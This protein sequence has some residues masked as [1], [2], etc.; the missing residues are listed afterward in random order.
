VKVSLL[1]LADPLAGHPAWA[2]AMRASIASLASRTM[3]TG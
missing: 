1:D 2:W 3:P